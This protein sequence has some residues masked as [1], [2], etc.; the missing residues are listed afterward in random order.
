MATILVVDEN[1]IERRVMRMTLEM[2]GHRVAEAPDGN[3]ALTIMEKYDLDLALVAMDMQILDGYQLI[4]KARTLP[5]REH[6]QFVAV[7]EG[8]DEKGPV[9]SFMAGATDLLIR[10]FGSPELRAAVAHSTSIEEIDL[11]QRLV[12]IQLEAYETAVRL[13]EQARH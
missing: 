7:L 13:Q 5:G 4:A 10:P 3:E 1:S 11:R 12:G 8:S 2:D 6:V 9:E